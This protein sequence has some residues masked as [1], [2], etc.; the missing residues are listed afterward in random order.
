MVPPIHLHYTRYAQSQTNFENL[1][2]PMTD[3]AVDG[4]DTQ[5][6]EKN[7]DSAGQDIQSQFIS[8]ETLCTSSNLRIIQA[9]HLENRLTLSSI[10]ICR[11][12]TS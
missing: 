7:I 3:I 8:N 4:F 2:P 11:C 1:E 12:L 9:T 5:E 6:T 10:Q